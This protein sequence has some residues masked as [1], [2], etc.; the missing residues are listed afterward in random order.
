MKYLYT[1]L[2]LD[3]NNK[4]IILANHKCK[5]DFNS[6][7]SSNRMEKEINEWKSNH[8]IFKAFDSKNLTLIIT[9][10]IRELGNIFPKQNFSDLKKGLE[11]DCI[12]IRKIGDKD[13]LNGEYYAFFKDEKKELYHDI[14]KIIFVKLGG[15]E[16]N[17]EVTQDIIDLLVENDYLKK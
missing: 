14:L 10:A 11:L 2:T 12:S 6:C 15:N 13:N 4:E 1:E 7:T 16:R 8:K 3:E 5:P 9:Q 17:L